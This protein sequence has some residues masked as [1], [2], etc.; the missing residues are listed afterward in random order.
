MSNKKLTTARYLLKQ[1]QTKRLRLLSL[2]NYHYLTSDQLAEIKNR[3]KVY[4][5]DKDVIDKLYANAIAAQENPDP[6]PSLLEKRVHAQLMDGSFKEYV[7]WN[8]VINGEKQIGG[9]YMQEN[10]KLIRLEDLKSTNKVDLEF[11]ENLAKFVTEAQQLGAEGKWNDNTRREL[12]SSMIKLV[13]SNPEAVR[14]VIFG[15][16]TADQ[17]EGSESSYATIFLDRLLAD[18]GMSASVSEAQKDVMIDELKNEN[19]I[20][21]FTDYFTSF[22]DKNAKIGVAVAG[23][24][25]NPQRKRGTDFS[26]PAILEYTSFVDSYNLPNGSEINIPGT[27]QIATRLSNGMYQIH[28]SKGNPITTTATQT[29]RVITEDNLIAMAELPDSFKNQLK[30]QTGQKPR[31]K[32]DEAPLELTPEEIDKLMKTH[33]R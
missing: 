28:D 18:N 25:P 9:Y 22:I 10:G 19:L 17:T 13:K 32:S 16:F 12:V 14:P 21:A 1:V 23:K 8:P 20:P 2:A 29:R 4:K 6:H 11:E 31:P 24:K 26:A 7:T 5:K 27:S 33:F 30:K 3:F 15:G